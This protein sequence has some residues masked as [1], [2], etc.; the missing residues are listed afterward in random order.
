M[1]TPNKN[2]IH[3]NEIEC[4]EA[5]VKWYKPEKGYGFLSSGNDTEDIFLHFS[6][7]DKYGC[8]NVKAGDRIICEVGSGNEG[9]RALDVL[10][11]KFISRELGEAPDVPQNYLDK[12]E[13]TIKWFNP[14]KKYGFVTPDDGLSD[15]FLHTSVLLKA[16]YKSIKPGVRILFNRIYSEGKYEVT[17]FE[18]ID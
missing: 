16:G 3:E 12:L 8:L 5:T 17:S 15:V 14:F 7:L 2:K 9:R 13:G 11:I 18:V 1:R 4:I 10:G 6:V